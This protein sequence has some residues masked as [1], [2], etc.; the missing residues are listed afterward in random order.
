VLQ[1][2]SGS[3]EG[4]DPV[5]WLRPGDRGVHWRSRYRPA[6]SDAVAGTAAR[7]RRGGGA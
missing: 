1:A 3:L 6:P 4:A 5:Y 2:R 7:W